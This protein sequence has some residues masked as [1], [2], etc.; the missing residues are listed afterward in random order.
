MSYVVHPLCAALPEMPLDEYNAF[1]KDI[2][3]NG[4]HEPI[5]LDQKGRVV[6]GRHRHRACDELGIKPNYVM[7]DGDDLEV[8]AFIL[9]ANCHRRH[10]SVRER[11]EL[12]RDLDPTADNKKLA[13]LLGVKDSLVRSMKSKDRKRG[14][15][16][17]GAE[18]ADAAENAQ[19]RKP[20]D[21]EAEVSEQPEV[22]PKDAP[23]MQVLDGLGQVVPRPSWPLFEKVGVLKVLAG[24]VRNVGKDVQRVATM[25]CAQ[26]IPIAEVMS[27]LQQAEALIRD[28]LPY[29]LVPPE[30]A[31][32]SPE[33]A[34]RGYLTVG[35][36]K[37]LPKSMKP[38]K[39]KK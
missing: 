17:A 23:P 6:D 13:A 32:Q 1:K 18:I 28:A 36:Y 8:A 2:E 25:P 37:R 19:E 35:Q 38:D 34:K 24:D 26:A 15:K 4:V 30:V 39:D 33:I 7:L 31:K 12:L 14:A 11:F 22:A 5:T 3:K 20:E 9:S 29:C 27:A 21:G 16:A 10:L